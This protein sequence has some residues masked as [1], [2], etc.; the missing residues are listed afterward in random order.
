MTTKLARILWVTLL[1]TACSSGGTVA[2]TIAPV[3]TTKTTPVAS[4][5]PS[6][7]ASSITR[8]EYG[9]QWPFTVPAGTLHCYDDPLNARLYVTFS[10]EGEAGVEYA[11]NGSARDFGFPELDASILVDYPD[12]SK[13]LSLI[14]TG[15]ALCG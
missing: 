14:E 11:L 13:T 10:H 3:A 4:P 12:R 9:A 6:A 7:P 15:L 8:A 5:T 1:V 2:P